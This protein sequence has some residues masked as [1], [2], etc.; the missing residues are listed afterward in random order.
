MPWFNALIRDMQFPTNHVARS[1]L[2]VVIRDK[3]PKSRYH[4]LVLPWADIDNVYQ[5]YSSMANTIDIPIYR[6]S[7]FQLTSQH[8]PLLNEMLRLGLQAIEVSRCLRADFSMGFHMKPSMRRLHLHVI[9]NDFTG[10]GMKTEKHW[11]IF[12]TDLFMPFGSILAELEERGH[13]HQRSPAYIQSLLSTPLECN[14]CDRQF[15]TIVTLKAHL[16]GH[17]VAIGAEP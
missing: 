14:Q 8:I 16:L 10:R 2:A 9:S 11:N 6:A 5:V 4:F 3:F 7:S 12:H 13:I 15:E 17:L 1:D